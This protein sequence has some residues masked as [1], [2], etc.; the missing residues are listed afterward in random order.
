MFLRFERFY[1]LFL[2]AILSSICLPGMVLSKSLVYVLIFICLFGL[3]L[4]LTNTIG[5][6]WTLNT[7]VEKRIQNSKSNIL[8]IQAIFGMIL[9]FCLF[10]T[11]IQ[12]P[13]LL[14]HGHI[15]SND[16]FLSTS[17]VKVHLKKP[18]QSDGSYL[19]QDHVTKPTIERRKRQFA[20]DYTNFINSTANSTTT[21]HKVHLKKPSDSDGSYLEQSHITKKPHTVLKPI[22]Y[23]DSLVE[24][25]ET[26]QKCL[27]N[28]P[29]TCQFKI[30]ECKPINNKLNGTQVTCEFNFNEDKLSSDAAICNQIYLTERDSKEENNCFYKR[31]EIIANSL[32]LNEHLDFKCVLKDS[33]CSSQQSCQYL[34]VNG[35]KIPEEVDK[36]FLTEI[37]KATS[38]TTMRSNLKTTIPTTTSI[39]TT[40]TISTST[41]AMFNLSMP[42]NVTDINLV[43]GF[44]TNKIV[45]IYKVTSELEH[46]YFLL[47]FMY[48]LIALL[49]S[50]MLIKVIKSV[51]ISFFKTV[52][53]MFRFIICCC[54]SQSSNLNKS[55]VNYHLANN[56]DANSMPLLSLKSPFIT[57]ATESQRFTCHMAIANIH[58]WLVVL[59]MFM[60]GGLLMN[61]LFLMQAYLSHGTN[62]TFT[63]KAFLIS[64]MFG[65]CA[66][67]TFSSK[68]NKLADTSIIRPNLYNRNE[69][70]PTSFFK[71]NFKLFISV[72]SITALSITQLTPLNVSPAGNL[73]TVLFGIVY[74]ILISPIVP[75]LLTLCE[76]ALLLN[77]NNK[78]KYISS[79]ITQYLMQSCLLGGVVVT[80]VDNNVLRGL[81]KE[82]E[83]FIVC[84]A[85]QSVGILVVLFLCATMAKPKSKK[86]NR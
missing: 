19:E 10:A 63:I 74:P 52:L 31:A 4:G 56:R 41:S 71:A 3:C 23:D 7:D 66:F 6:K 33:E 36:C 86:P 65:R 37:N 60:Y 17:T 34:P 22:N 51:L 14:T 18:G 59:V 45:S 72:L 44:L 58:F 62:S 40:T 47:S 42:E 46:F 61:F 69:L 28:L 1:L 30:T 54:T 81:F 38:T 48:I 32:K 75:M 5:L 78:S 84:N 77:E 43:N 39:T 26:L 24:S 12:S 82:G 8:I 11:F 13:V 27:K 80:F 29:R 21:T 2:C 25:S 73:A 68:A 55:T 57:E 9:F 64:F 35:Q 67:I 70:S 20:P 83:I 76:T 53:Y 85:T 49:H 79:Y 16:T 15:G 50:L